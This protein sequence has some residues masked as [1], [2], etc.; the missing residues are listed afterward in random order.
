MVLKLEYSVLS[1]T[2]PMSHPD[3]LPLW[4][5]GRVMGFGL[6]V[7]GSNPVWYKNFLRRAA[8]LMH[9][10]YQENSHNHPNQLIS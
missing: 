1:Y 7:M 3:V 9:F 8:S 5:G 10:S 6:G 4:S 2:V